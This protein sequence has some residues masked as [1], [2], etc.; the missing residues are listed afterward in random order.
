MSY[1]VHPVD[2]EIDAVL[3]LCA[4]AEAT[5]EEKFPAMTYEQGVA[6]AIRWIIGQEKEQPLAD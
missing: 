2:A 5:G 4:D 1:Q 3:N 6:Y